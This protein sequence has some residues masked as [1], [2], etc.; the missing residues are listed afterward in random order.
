[1]NYV[2][3]SYVPLIK[4]DEVQR[5]YDPGKNED[6]AKQLFSILDDTPAV[7]IDA[8][9]WV[10]DPRTEEICPVLVTKNAKAVYEHLKGWAENKPQK[11]FQVHIEKVD[12][13]YVVILF[14][15]LDQSISRF[16]TAC[17]HFTGEIPTQDSEFTLIFR[18]IQ[19]VSNNSETF[20]RISHLIKYPLMVGMMDIEDFSAFRDAPEENYDKILFLDHLEQASP[21]NP[22]LEQV[23]KDLCDG[24]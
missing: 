24:E 20:D 16:K 2:V 15:D 4:Y 14:P 1:M 21:D 23:R 11:W 13:R 18:A 5:I 8:C 10:A 12:D 22:Y 3:V 7:D 9:V 6:I 19:F 17:L